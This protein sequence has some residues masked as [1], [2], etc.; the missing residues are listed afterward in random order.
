MIKDLIL[1]SRSYRGFFE[2][3]NLQDRAPEVLIDLARLSPSG[4]NLKGLK[5]YSTW[6]S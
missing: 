6:K 2:E 4:G 3:E 5:Y 1:K